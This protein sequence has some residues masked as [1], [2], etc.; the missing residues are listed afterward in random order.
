[1]SQQ[2]ATEVTEDGNDVMVKLSGDIDLTC[3]ESLFN[4]LC[5]HPVEPGRTVTVDLAGVGFMDST[6]LN[7]LARAR[8][9]CEAN[10]VRLRVSSPRPMVARVLE[11]SGLGQYLGY[12]T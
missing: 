5:R 6:G 1:V 3:R 9:L 7:V 8:E 10:G 12:P 11:I 2:L 4:E